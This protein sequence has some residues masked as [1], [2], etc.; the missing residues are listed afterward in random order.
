M[1]SKLP[2]LP[3][4]QT[5]GDD[6]KDLIASALGLK[7]GSFVKIV[8]SH[9]T[10]ARAD[11]VQRALYLDTPA[12]RASF[13]VPK[14]VSQSRSQPSLRAETRASSLRARATFPSSSFL[15]VF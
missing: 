12:K 5:E 3:D 8:P 11:V 4:Y 15:F 6:Y 14:L 1:P 2:H 10:F 7:D 9:D 13:Q